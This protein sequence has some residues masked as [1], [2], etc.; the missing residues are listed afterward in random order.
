MNARKL[1]LG[2]GVCLLVAA[3]ATLV[4]E[5]GLEKIEHIVVI[6][7]ENRS[8]DHLYGLFPGANGIA[9]AT[10]EQKTQLDLDGTALPHL[11]A[12]FTPQGKP[13][14]RF[15][16]KLSNGPFRIDAPPLSR[17]LDELLPSPIHAY[18]Q[19]RQQING[20][21]NNLFTAMSAVG[22]WT[23]G[24][25]DGSRFKLWQWARAHESKG[26]QRPAREHEQRPSTERCLRR[27]RRNAVF[28]S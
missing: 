6:Y 23:M 16:Q 9:D 27:E 19:N 1:L 20:G 12:V 17:R 11:P 28:D 3:C 8:F 25:Y 14:E 7:A 10:D 4:P 2:V 22:G 15:P 26:R 24:Y 13:D 21:R 5:G 18:Y